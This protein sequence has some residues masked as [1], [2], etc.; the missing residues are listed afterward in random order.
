MY[1]T[2][3][4]GTNNMKLLFFSSTWCTNCK[5]LKLS[6][7]QLKLDT[8]DLDADLHLEDFKK[9]NIRNIPTLMLLDNNGVEIQRLT[10]SQ[11]LATLQQLKERIEND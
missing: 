10:G 2:L 11:T 1:C 8:V 3:Q 4:D 5:P 7:Q 6:I 9:Y